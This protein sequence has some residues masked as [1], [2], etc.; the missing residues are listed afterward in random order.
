MILIKIWEFEGVFK[1]EREEVRNGSVKLRVHS[2]EVHSL[3]SSPNIVRMIKLKR[4]R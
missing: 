3:Y 1:N 4:M 2:V